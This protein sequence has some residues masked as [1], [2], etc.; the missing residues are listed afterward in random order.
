MLELDGKCC[1]F[2][3]GPMR[4]E[5][6]PVRYLQNT[7]SGKMGLAFAK[8][9]E[10]RGA[11]IQVLL[12]PVESPMVEAFSRFEVHR[13]QSASDYEKSLHRLF[14]SCDIFFSLAAV[15][16]FEVVALPQKIAREELG[17]EL[18]LEVRKVPDFAAWAGRAKRSDQMLIAFAAE[19]GSPEEMLERAEGKRKRKNADVILANPVRKGLGPGAEENEIWVIRPDQN[20]LHL[21]PCEKGILAE[22][23]LETLFPSHKP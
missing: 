21:G 7:S 5:V 12:G 23:V 1:L 6:D 17:N 8:A 3:V 2:S 14:P 22:A 20:T 18:K 11:K 19:S 16:D 9:A 10:K 15:L 4:T 13:Y